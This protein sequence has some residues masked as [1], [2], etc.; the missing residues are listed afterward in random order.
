MKAPKIKITNVGGE[1]FSGEK[2]II[3]ITWRGRTRYVR[4]WDTGGCRPKYL[5]RKFVVKLNDILDQ[6]STEIQILKQIRHYDKKYFPK[7]LAICKDET[8]IVQER[9]EFKREQEVSEKELNKAIGIIERLIQKYEIG[10]VTPNIYGDNWA[11]R[12]DGRPVI[13]DF[14]V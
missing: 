1:C 5:G 13:Y 11:I 4:C 7:I 12:K 3:R 9:I 2:P 14:G 8:F 10:D 6:T